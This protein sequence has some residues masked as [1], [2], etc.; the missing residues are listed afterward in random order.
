MHLPGPEFESK[1]LR[2]LPSPCERRRGGDLSPVQIVSRKE[3]YL[4]RKSMARR[5][6]RNTFRIDM[7]KGL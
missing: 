4:N 3:E 2:P 7:D 6:L 1:P 5:K